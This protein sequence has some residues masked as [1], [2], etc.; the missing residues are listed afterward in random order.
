MFI[1]FILNKPYKH[2]IRGVIKMIAKHWKKIGLLILIICCLYNITT[3]LVK[4]T[5]LNSE[6]KQTAE[7]VLNKENK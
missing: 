6:L 2:I 3:K 7:Y 5:S 1:K 4:R